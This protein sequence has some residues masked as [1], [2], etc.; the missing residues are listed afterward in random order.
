VEEAPDTEINEGHVGSQQEEPEHVESQ[1]DESPHADDEVNKSQHDDDDD[2]EAQHI[3][4]KVNERTE[5]EI[6]PNKEEGKKRGT[7]K[8]KTYTRTRASERLSG[9][10]MTTGTV[11]PRR[12][13]QR[14]SPLSSRLQKI[15]PQPWRT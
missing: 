6:V 4:D 1:H 12:H 11:N 7:R 2:D 8:R 10:A 14:R 3:D 15:R 9:K 13:L 5:A